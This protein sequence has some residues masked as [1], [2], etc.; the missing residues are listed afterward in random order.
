MVI[1]M[2]FW[3]L[4]S[5]LHIC[6]FLLSI[7]T[8]P[9]SWKLLLEIKNK[10]KSD[11]TTLFKDWA[12]TH[13]QNLT[14][15]PCIF[16]SAIG[17]WHLTRLHIVQLSGNTFILD[18]RMFHKFAHRDATSMELVVPC[19]RVQCNTR[20]SLFSPCFLTGFTSESFPF[21]RTSVPR[22]PPEIQFSHSMPYIRGLEG[23]WCIHYF[24]HLGE[25]SRQRSAD[26]RQRS[27]IKVRGSDIR[28]WMYIVLTKYCM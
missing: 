25:N 15:Y 17:H 16:S 24:F 22:S 27:N 4:V 18:T 26:I 11:H 9:C 5:R 1:R 23:W 21:R 14:F 7:E 28:P 19:C 8:L 2:C 20:S 12:F 6:F 10:D 13:S 3:C